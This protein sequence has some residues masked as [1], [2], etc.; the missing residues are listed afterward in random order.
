MESEFQYPEIIAK[1]SKI[2]EYVTNVIT[3]FFLNLPNFIY[4]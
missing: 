4:L 1:S 3:S 2:G